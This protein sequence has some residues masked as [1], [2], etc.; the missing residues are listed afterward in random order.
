MSRSKLVTGK[1]WRF[2]F[3]IVLI[4]GIAF[5]FANLDQKIYWEDETSTSLRAA[6]H[7]TRQAA[8]RFYTGQIIS[9]QDLLDYQRPASDS[10]L[11]DVVR[12]AA[13]D[14]GHPPLYFLFARLWS[15]WLGGSAV[16]MRL[17]P[18]ILSLLSFP[19]IYWLCLE[20]FRSSMVGWV[21][22]AL[23]S[24]SPIFVRYSQESRHYS[25]WIVLIL[26]SGTLLVRAIY[27]GKRLNWFTYTLS[28]IAGIYTHLFSIFWL[29]GHG[30]YTIVV[31]RFRLKKI[32]FSYGISLVLI[33][34]SFIPWVKVSVPNTDNFVARSSWVN[35]PL[36]FSDLA[37]AWGLNFSRTFMSWELRYN[38]VLI[39]LWIPIAILVAYSFI[40]LCQRSPRKTWLFILTSAAIPVLTL[41]SMD[42]ILGGQR[43][44]SPQYFF[45][46]Y[47]SIQ[48]AVAYLLTNKINHAK[49][50]HRKFWQIITI[51]LIASG[52]ASC[53]I[54]AQS[55]TWWGWSEFELRASQIINQAASPLIISDV[56]FTR[57]LPL[58]HKLDPKVRFMLLTEPKNE[59]PSLDQFSDVFIYNPSE[60]LLSKLKEKND[61]QPNVVYEFKEGSFVVPLYKIK[62]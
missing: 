13:E 34:L 29:T 47:I 40:F 4:L 7:T 24:V 38:D 30:I 19:L 57:I 37:S 43:S 48:I 6:G 3:I 26:L 50:N 54:N 39:Y 21:S 8:E 60:Q 15:Q 10:T 9:V 49:Y 55:E 2:F 36:P 23:I 1:G 41:V 27:Y 14:A 45:P 5:R 59:F 56:R 46:C 51:F 11:L 28:A 62:G 22:I 17:L 31:E 12:V 32:L 52:I 61:A 18:V 16:V 35:T 58:S 25:L 33:C 20:L 42:L 44:R 53:A